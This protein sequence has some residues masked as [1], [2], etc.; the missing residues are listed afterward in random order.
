MILAD[1]EVTVKL[2]SKLT[3]K[4]LLTRIERLRTN[5]YE[6]EIVPQIVMSKPSTTDE[7]PG[8][9]PPSASGPRKSL[10]TLPPLPQQEKASKKKDNGKKPKQEEIVE[11]K[12]VPVEEVKLPEAP[13]LPQPTAEEIEATIRER[14]EQIPRNFEKFYCLLIEQHQLFQKSKEMIEAATH[15]KQHRI[16]LEQAA[17]VAKQR[18]MVVKPE[19]V[20]GSKED[21][22]MRKSTMDLA[23]ILADT[24]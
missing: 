10:N 13:P 18:F 6:F 19:S 4:S 17:M 9:K 12:E 8:T 23:S 21:L 2:C 24:E 14:L 7:Q 1:F 15:R 5:G 20:R 22:D 3:I 11:V 16:A